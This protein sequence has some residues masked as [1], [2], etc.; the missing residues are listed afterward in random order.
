M[1]KIIG[2]IFLSCLMACGQTKLQDTHSV[3]GQNGA[4][5]NKTL[6]FIDNQWLNIVFDF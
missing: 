2:I 4:F 3:I 5:E 1:K 6:F